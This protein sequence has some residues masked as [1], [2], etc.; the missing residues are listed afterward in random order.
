MGKKTKTPKA[1][2]Y[3]GLANQQAAQAKEA[4]GTALQANR[5]SQTNQF[6]NLSW[7]QDP[8]TGQWT[9]NTQLN[10]PQQDIFNAQQGNQ[11]QIANM[12]GGML[13]GLDTSQIDFSGAP[14][15]GQ[16]GQFN[17]QATDLYRQLG[18]PDLDRS[19]NA[20]RAD[21]AARGISDLN[22][23]AGANLMQQLGD[24]TN[25]FGMEAAQRGITQ[26]NTMF[27]QQNQLHQQGIQDILAQAPGESRTGVRSDGTRAADGCATVQ[28]VP[29]DRR[30]PDPRPD[31]C[32]AGQLQRADGQYQ[33]EELGLEP[34]RTDR[35]HSRH[36]CRSSPSKE[37]IM[38][39]MAGTLM[40]E[41]Q[42]RIL[43]QQQPLIDAL[44][45]NGGGA[46]AFNPA[47]T[48]G[49][50]GGQ[51]PQGTD[52]FGNALGQALGQ[53]GSYL[54][55]NFATA[56]QYGTNPLSQQ[57]NMLQAQDAAFL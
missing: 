43:Q 35:R 34:Q 1:P 4:W 15:M 28:P 25:R 20:R 50:Q 44:R 3:T 49:V 9:Q 29:V 37:K 24:Q 18:Q 53:G 48:A 42:A 51:M 27:G 17:Q 10:Q 11:Q 6:G 39:T 23:G 32:G 2:D 40:P 12:A 46:M 22:S 30:L 41:E 26:G 31:G 54:K 8:V 56:N 57:T 19:Q 21:L 36:C 33:R 47:A 55:Q 45:A 5:P 13:G 52:Q 16:V 7:E 38:Q 14:A